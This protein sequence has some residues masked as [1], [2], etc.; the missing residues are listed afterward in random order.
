MV[1]LKSVTADNFWDIVSLSLPRGQQGFVTTNAVSIAQAYAQPECLPL[2]IYHGDTPVGFIM[3]CIDRDD[4][5]YWLYRLMVDKHHQNKGYGRAALR[6]ALQIIR[7]DTARRKIFLG[8]DPAAQAAVHLYQSEGFSFNG[9][10]FGKEHIMLLELPA[11]T[12]GR[13]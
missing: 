7:Q 1:T 5:E 9:Q 8:V 13:L 3:Y 11:G 10:V 4:N 6:Q 12:P 2:A